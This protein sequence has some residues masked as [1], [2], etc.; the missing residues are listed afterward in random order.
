VAIEE[1][2]EGSRMPN[3]VLAD[4][5]CFYSVYHTGRLKLGCLVCYVQN[6]NIPFFVLLLKCWVKLL[7][8]SQDIGVKT[9]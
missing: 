7:G 2:F 8:M 3:L 4:V 1:I 6:Y 5:S 9:L